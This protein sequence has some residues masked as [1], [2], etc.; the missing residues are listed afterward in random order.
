MA[1]ADTAGHPT[2]RRTVLAGAGLA[3]GATLAS[4]LE[5]TAYAAAHHAGD[6]LLST[7]A[8]HLVGRFSYG[9]TPA[10]A[11]QVPGPWR[12]PELVPVAAHAGRVKDPAGE[13]L[14]S[15]FPH[16]KWSPG[17]I[18]AENDSGRVGGW[19]VMSTTRTPCCC[20]G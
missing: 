19:E 15:W 17:K 11:K 7:Q 8:R 14:H 10:L 5:G 2:A 4:G 9:V 18:A 3:A 20:A 6:P 12:R 16:L 13:A 1:V